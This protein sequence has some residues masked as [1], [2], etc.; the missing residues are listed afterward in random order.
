M[1]RPGDSAQIIP[2]HFAHPENLPVKKNIKCSVVIVTWN[3]RQELEKAL[4]SIYAQTV[5]HLLEVIVIDNAS[6]DD[7]IR[8]LKEDYPHPVRLYRFDKNLGASVARNSGIKL[9]QNKFICF[10]DSDAEILEPATIENCLNKLI[11]NPEIQAVG[12]HIWFDRERTS[13]FSKGG[14]ITYDGVFDQRR[15]FSETANPMFL[16]TCFSVWRRK[17]LLQ[18]R[19]FDPWYF[20]GIED[21]DLGLRGT[22]RHK[23]QYAIEDNG[24]VLHEMSEMG[25][26]YSRK[27]FDKKFMDYELQ[28]FYLILSYGG[29]LEFFKRLVLGPFRIRRVEETGWLR[30]LTFKQRF[31]MVVLFPLWRLLLLPRDYVLQRRNFIKVTTRRITPRWMNSKP[32]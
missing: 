22:F 30:K 18:L 2:S 29:L 6:T 10:L 32:S 14:Y 28:R 27:D 16:T 11:E 1:T 13:P 26:E 15:T 8:W 19:G 25:R 31:A 24:A 5:A 4:D 21:V 17:H 7:T 20:F 9:A 3:R 12:T 23:A